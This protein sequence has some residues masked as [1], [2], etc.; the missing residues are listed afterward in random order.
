MTRHLVSS[1][2]I[3]KRILTKSLAALAFGALAIGTIAALTTSNADASA[4]LVSMYPASTVPATTAANDAQAV[5]LG[6]KFKASTAGSIVGVRYYKSSRNSGTHAGS[7]WNSA[8]TKLATATFS[9][10]TSSGWQTV[11]FATAVAI[12]PG[13]TYTASYH[14]TTGY[15]AVKQGTFAN[16]ATIGTGVV[17]GSAGVFRYGSVAFPTSTYRYSAYYVDVLFQP[18]D[19]PTPT[20]TPTTTAPTPTPTPTPTTT[21]PTPDPDADSHADRP[22][23]LRRRGTP[24]HRPERRPASPLR[25]CPATR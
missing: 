21:A 10:E 9:G 2:V 3:P 18:A 15:Y 11:R 17:K 7:L 4:P 6:V 25:R 14:T 22:R 19:A 12:T 20:P 23:P 13:A 24:R 16:G 5:E 8:G 1:S